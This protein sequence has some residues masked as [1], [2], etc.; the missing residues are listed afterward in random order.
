MSNQ[1][2]RNNAK[3][4]PEGRIFDGK[5]DFEFFDT[6]DFSEPLFYYYYDIYSYT[7]LVQLGYNYIDL[8]VAVRGKTGDPRGK[9][10]QEEPKS[11]KLQ[12]R[13]ADVLQHCLD[14][15]R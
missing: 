2:G 1:T 5:P 3:L 13:C 6:T 9:T 15:S 11:D 8:V 10:C 7:R 14:E 4:A 12:L